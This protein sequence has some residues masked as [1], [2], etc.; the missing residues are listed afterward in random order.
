MRILFL[1]INV[2]AVTF[3]SYS[4]NDKAY[5]NNKQLIEEAGKLYNNQKYVEALNLSKKVLSN[6][7]LNQDDYHLALSYN[8]VGSIYTEFSQTE[9]G[10]KFYNKALYYANKIDNDELRLWITSN[11]GNV[12]YYNESDVNKGIKYYAKSLQLAEKLKDSLQISFI[13][14]NIANAYIEIDKLEEGM[15]Y[16]NPIKEYIEKQD[17]AAVRISYFDYLGKYLSLKNENAEAEKYFIKAINLALKANSTLQLRDSYNNLS[18]HYRNNKKEAQA[19]KYR[20]LAK[21]LDV[22]VT[23]KQKLDSIDKIAIQIE[24]DEYKYQFEQIELKNELQNEKFRVARIINIV[25]IISIVILLILLYILYKN[26]KI[27]KNKNAELFVANQELIIAQK[28]TE[29]NALLKSQFI[30]TVSHE[31]RTPLY[32][33][34]GLTNI[35][36]EENKDENI[37]E[38]LKSLQFSAQ[39]LFALIND[40]LEINKAEEMKIVLNNSIFNIKEELEVINNSLSHFANDN[41]NTLTI[42]VDN[43]IPKN[44]IGDKLRLSQILINLIS[45]ALKFTENGKVAIKANL[46]NIFDNQCQIE[47]CVSDT[48]I[49]IK[50]EDQQKIFDKFVQID[51]K[52]GDY[53]GTGLGLSIVRKL[54]ELFGGTISVSSKENEGTTFKV[55]LKFEFINEVPNQEIKNIENTYMERELQFLVVE[56]NMINQI[57]TKKIIEQKNHQCTIVEDGF[58]ALEILKSTQFDIILMDINM[59]KIDGYETSKLIRESGITTPII[60]LTAFDKTEVEAKITECGITDVIIK[61]FTP[62]DLFEMTYKLIN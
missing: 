14:L 47:I 1:F 38:N 40:L 4:K 13:S 45:N 55:I 27:R 5:Q 39:Y 11:I 16:I 49:G 56:D 59:P 22:K 42:D 54:V 60:A 12:F 7:L 37:R 17:N 29:E 25:I 15:K 20:A 50:E 41:G 8:L 36:I 26:N 53:Q 10:L 23:A 24:L 43:K 61:P 30:S 32:G 34:I 31:L 62:D 44:L 35:I 48:G 19:N 6:S 51:R 46:I 28:R 2:F 57:V 21:Q 3:L 33:V 52:K 58:A 18:F 9:R